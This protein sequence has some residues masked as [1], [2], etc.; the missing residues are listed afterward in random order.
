M[1]AFLVLTGLEDFLPKQAGQ[2]HGTW[3]P[4]GYS[5]KIAIVAI[6]CLVGRWAWRDFLPLPGIRTMALA[7]ALGLAVTVA[8]VGLESIP[9]PKLNLAGGHRQAF[10]P[11]SLPVGKRAAFLAVRLFGLVLLV[12]LMEEL[13]WRSFLLRWVIDSE[14][15]RVPIGRVTLGAAAVTS[16]LFAAAHPEW[17]PALLT[18]AA[19]AWLLWQTK[20]LFA[21]FL[22]HAVANLGLGIYVLATHN[23]RFW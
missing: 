15:R 1:A 9:Y 21:C 22:S 13:F 17:L 16:G 14:F 18:G 5:V 19:W 4:I 3:Y 7:V 6:L 8:W 23:W 10:D 11:Y 2:P 20:S 12:P